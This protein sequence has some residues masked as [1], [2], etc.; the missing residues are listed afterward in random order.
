MPRKLRDLLAETPDTLD[1]VLDDV[2]RF[3]DDGDD[4]GTPDAEAFE[5]E[6]LRRI[7]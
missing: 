5:R 4:D 1:D 6:Y 7:R 2:E 3:E